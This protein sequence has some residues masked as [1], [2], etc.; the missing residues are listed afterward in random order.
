MRVLYDAIVN[1]ELI[2]VEVSG[3]KALIMTSDD[4]LA[5]M[6]SVID[7]NL[8]FDSPDK[9]HA[10]NFVSKYTRKSVLQAIQK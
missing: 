1:R 5:D 10:N 8:L 7:G 3:G 9:S 6:K 4:V 2:D